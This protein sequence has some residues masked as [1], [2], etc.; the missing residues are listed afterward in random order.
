MVLRIGRL[1][2]ALTLTAG[3]ACPV[4]AGPAGAPAAS[5]KD[6]AARS[7]FEA[8]RGQ[9]AAP[10][11]FFT[12][13]AGYN[14]YLTAQEAVI[15]LP[16]A[17]GLKPGVLRMKL[18]GANA[19]PA[20]KGQG[21][22]PGYSNYLLGADRS[23]WRTGVKHYS[24][25][26]LG[27]VYPGIDMVYRFNQ[28]NVEHDYI[29]AP[30][31]DPRR[32]LFGFEGA[33][34]LRLDAKGGLVLRVAAG[35]LTY[36]APELY[37]TLGSRRVSVKGRFALAANNN[38]RIEVGNYIKSKELVIDPALSYSSFLGGAGAT[39]DQAFAIA[40]DNNRN[41][42]VTG[43]TNSPDFPDAVGGPIQA[44][45]G[46]GYDIFVTKINPA[47][48]GIVWS[49]YLGGA[50]N[51]AGLGI[52]VDGPSGRAYIT[53]SVAGGVNLPGSTP[54]TG[55]VG[56][57]TGI[58][59]F[60]VG[61]AA[62]GQ[63]TTC[64]VT[65]GADGDDIGNGIA[66]DSGE[67]LYVTGT[68]TAGSIIDNTPHNA[69]ITTF[70]TTKDASP[71]SGTRSVASQAFVMKF[72]KL[73]AQ[74]YGTYL[75]CTGFAEGRGI[76]VDGLNGSAYVT[77]NTGDGFDNAAIAG[78]F[79]PT[80]GGGSGEGDAF[81]A[82]LTPTATSFD[83]KTYI[84]G[85]N[86]D[87]G[88]AIAVDS[89]KDVY[90]TGYTYSADFP[91]NSTVFATIPGLGGGR[92]TM[93]TGPDAFV[94]K[95]RIGNGGGH[96]DGVY[97]TYL[98]GNTDDRGTGIKVDSS[99]N[100]YVTGYTTSG[101]YPVVG[102]NPSA[103][104]STFIGTPEAFVTELDSTGGPFIFSTWLGGTGPTRGQGLA[105]D[106]LKNIY[107]TGYT[108]SGAGTF[109]LVAG[110]FQQTRGTGTNT[111]FVT[112]FGAAVPPAVCSITSIYPASGFTV[113]GTTVTIN[114]ANFTGFTGA[115]VTFDGVNT[116]KYSVNASSTVL[117]AIAPR[118]PV[119]GA[120]VVGAVPLKVTALTGSCSKTYNYVL[121]AC[122]NDLFFPSPAKGATGNFSYC[123]AQP[124]TVRVRIYNV[125]G[126][127]AA[128][129]EDVRP[130][131]AGLSQLNTA[132]LA[133]GVYL[134]RLE[135]DYGG[136]NSTT[137]T[138]KKFVVQH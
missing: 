19:S 120:L 5:Y 17:A 121:S 6:A 3:P 92:T 98:G 81:I 53:G 31:A 41:A 99:F 127:L 90:I 36:K 54:L 135:K 7:Y 56:V 96:S 107:V 34:S 58:N 28:G 13:A 128:K 46:A 85:A 71:C 100:A 76:A 63:S 62:D 11:K 132:R 84:G 101:D 74:V 23:K 35:E 42:Y 129:L 67:N 83:Y 113:G 119:S 130:A 15:V 12:R 87:V 61:F 24:G 116:P 27:Q 137:S 80:W 32:I 43:T 44:A 93:S 75:G 131:G 89:L 108:G 134:Y 1:F 72:T 55:A 20:V 133:P 95:L 48:T 118:H 47:G 123:M 38:V 117:T 126:D 69:L 109:P 10:V 78:A 111:A 115:G 138:V 4:Y 21:I 114:I 106:S 30:G 124:G 16:A 50:T 136:G 33:Q 82:R 97:A 37:Q 22:L 105:L 112:K 60:L 77:G 110:G 29:V 94:F 125:I 65:F 57:L 52:A 122:G 79:K 68:T 14:L 103:G 39:E 86:D 51:D 64:S 25:V 18:K 45:K 70:P 91:D 73:G 40:V 9:T 8:N 26:R 59:A 102:A 104:Q 49:T 88:T 2:T 66:I